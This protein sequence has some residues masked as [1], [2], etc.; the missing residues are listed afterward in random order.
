MIKQGVKIII[1]FILVIIIFIGGWFMYKRL[2]YN[3]QSY[4]TNIYDYIPSQ[5]DEVF[6][7]NKEYN[8]KD[9]YVYD[10]GYKELVDVLH[11]GFS[12]P[13]V[14]CRAEEGRKLL[15]VKI[16]KDEE[17]GI[18]DHIKNHIAL[19]YKPG[20][21]E[22]NGNQIVIYPLP[23]YRFLVCTYYKG[24]LAMSMN[25]R[26]ITEFLDAKPDNSFFNNVDDVEL[27]DKRITNNPVSMFA[28]CGNKILALD[29]KVKNDTID[30]CGYIFDKQKGNRDLIPYQMI[31]P[32]N[33]CID[34][35]DILEE[36]NIPAIR[37]ILNK[38]Y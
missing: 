14:L 38:M 2:E 16:N 22:Y 13:F 30:L 25:F 6:N 35:Y 8:L 10:R 15:L 31:V 3:K 29:Y 12:Y 5:A 36:N 20:L 1:L 28:R 19:P 32:D 7:I 33:I 27:I 11:N 9:I 21:K 17:S 37:I 26:A 23:D 24:I 34:R 18:Y 4:D